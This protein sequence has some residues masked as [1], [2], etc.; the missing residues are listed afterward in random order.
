MKLAG[1]RPQMRLLAGQRL[2]VPAGVRGQVPG[3]GQRRRQAPGPGA[4]SD[5]GQLGENG[6]TPP[7]WRWPAAL[8]PCSPGARAAPAGEGIRPPAVAAP[9]WPAAAATHVAGYYAQKLRWTPCDSGFQ[10]ARLLVPFD[11]SRPAWRRFSL[12][13]IKLPAADPGD[14]IGSLVVNPGGPGGSG[15]QYALQ[16]RSAVSPAV[17]DRFDVVGFDPRGVGGS[18]AGRAL[19]DRARSSTSTTRPM[20]RRTPPAQLPPWSSREQAVRPECASNA[21]SLLPYVGTRTPRATW[22]CCAPRWATPSSPTSASPTGPSSAPGTRSSS[23]NHVRALVLDGALDPDATAPDINI[24]FRA[25]GSRSRSGR[26]PRTACGSRLPARP[27]AATSAR[28]S[29]GCRGC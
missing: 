24:T 20:T 14:R 9:A 12:P 2:R 1:G 3:T 28:A 5:E 22:T 29:P 7:P 8:P 13:V 19:H 4:G 15:V 10:C 11:Y 6:L 21:G 26:S 16:A 23:R 25:R 17:L 27:R 18:A